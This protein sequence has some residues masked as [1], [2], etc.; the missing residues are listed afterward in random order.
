MYKRQLIY[1]VENGAVSLYYDNS[2]KFETTSGGASV[3]GNLDVSS[4]VDVTG[5]ITVTGT[6]DGVDI[7]ALNTTVGNITTDLVSDTSPQLGGDFQSNGHDIK[8]ADATGYDGNNIYMGTGADCRI[9]H[10]GSN[11]SIAEATGDVTIQS[12]DDII[13]KP[14][15]GENG[16]KIIGNG[17]VEL[18]HD[19]TKMA[20]TSA[21]G[22]DVTNGDL[23]AHLDVKVLSDDRK[24][25][26]GAG[27][28]LR[29][30]HNC[31]LYTSPS[32][33]D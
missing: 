31:L 21:S 25:F 18:Y 5:D 15:G 10:D 2:K 8:I 29:L 1:G 33:R 16:I 9:H 32:P 14:Q 13:L 20:Y 30:Y 12:A 24:L 6:V 3:T 11:F 26:L 17:S 19:N 28:D 23:R 27:N 4:G 22:F 7:A